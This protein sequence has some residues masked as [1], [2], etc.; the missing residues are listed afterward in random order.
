MSPSSTISALARR[1]AGSGTGTADISAR[2]YGMGGAVVH[3]GGRAVLDDPPEVHHGDL[4]GD[5]PHDGEVVGDEQVRQSELVLEVLEQVDDLALHGHVERRD[6]LVAHEH[7]RLDGERP[8]DADALALPAGEL[9]RIPV[10]VAGVEADELEQIL[11]RPVP[12]AL[13]HG[14][15]VDAERLA[16]DLADAHPRVQ[17]RV[18]ILEHDL[19]SATQLAPR[20]PATSS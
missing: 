3:V 12:P 19:H 10:H 17:R 15:G 1:A 14:I 18:R 13:R 6:G 5:V 20:P 11:D 16:D 2:V 7:L 4:V 8:G 9:V